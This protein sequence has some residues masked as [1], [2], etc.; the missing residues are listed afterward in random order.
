M[1]VTRQSTLISVNDVVVFFMVLH[2]VLVDDITEL[3]V[4]GQAPP[5]NI[6]LGHTD[7]GRV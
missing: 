2:M 3:K 6:V 7:N 1:L 5:I 4:D